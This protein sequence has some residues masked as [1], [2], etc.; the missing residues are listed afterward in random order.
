MSLYA[1]AKRE[2]DA[3]ATP[4]D[5]PPPEPTG[6]GPIATAVLEPAPPARPAGAVPVGTTG[7]GQALSSIG[8]Y[9]PTEV[10]ATYLAI[11]AAIPSDRG[12]GFQWLMFWVFLIFTPIVVW[13]GVAVARQSQGI[14]VKP[15]QQWPWW[16]MIA[17]TVAFAAFVVVLPGS[18]TRDISWYEAWMGTVAIILS[19]FV[20]S[21]GDQL[22]GSRRSLAKPLTTP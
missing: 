21:I 8:T 15:A 14:V 3:L 10:M 22:F 11:L 19:A 9:I 5:E 12:H 2:V 20:L 13:L 4:A 7:V 18:V 17:A 1:I 16:S 6:G